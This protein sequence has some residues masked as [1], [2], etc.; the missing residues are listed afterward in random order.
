M[1]C[2]NQYH[3]G[4][5]GWLRWLGVTPDFRL[6]HGP[7]VVGLSPALGSMSAG[8]LLKIFSLLPPLPSPSTRP[9]VLPL[10]LKN[11]AC[12]FDPGP[13]AEICVI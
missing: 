3:P 8:S 1:I 9:H 5:P 7:R 4:L 2:E 11:S 12:T 10:C 6:G 13:H